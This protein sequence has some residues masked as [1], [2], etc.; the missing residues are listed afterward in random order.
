MRNIKCYVSSKGKN[1]VQGIYSSGTENLKAELEVALEYLKVR[2]RLE[3]RRPHAAKL[4]KCDGF[5]DFFEIR[6]FADRLQQRP[7][8]YFGPQQN[9]FTILLWATEKGG[10]LDPANWCQKAN[11]RRSE[12][13]DGVA[14]VIDLKLDGG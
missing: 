2:E 9:D 1:E 3:W 4:S 5:R 13:I 11:R 12:I 10:R 8:G 6:F 14:T 7:I